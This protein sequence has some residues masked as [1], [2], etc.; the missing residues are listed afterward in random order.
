VRT[1]TDDADKATDEIFERWL[2]GYVPRA[3]VV[4]RDLGALFQEAMCHEV[5][6]AITANQGVTTSLHFL[7][8]R[9]ETL[10]H[11]ILLFIYSSQFDLQLADELLDPAAVKAAIP[12][13]LTAQEVFDRKAEKL[14]RVFKAFVLSADVAAQHYVAAL[15]AS[16][17]APELPLVWQVP[18]EDEAKTG[19]PSNA[20]WWTT[21]QFLCEV[22]RAIVIYGGFTRHLFDELQYVRGTPHL[23]G[24][25]LWLDQ[26]MNLFFPDRLDEQW[27]VKDLRALLEKVEQIAAADEPQMSRA[28]TTNH[29]W[30]GFGILAVLAATQQARRRWH[31]A[32]PLSSLRG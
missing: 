6:G 29:T 23:R 24:R 27:S 10:P 28:S 7:R 15:M 17:K 22:A 32:L 30:L 14:E 18:A 2:T 16:G 12:E 11:P 5:P 13:G 9:R 21:F 8:E 3:E 4:E 1:I 25:V 31:W 19:F 26:D 20:M